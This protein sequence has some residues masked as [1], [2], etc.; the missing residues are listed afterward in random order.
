[1]RVSSEVFDKMKIEKIFP[2]AKENWNTLYVQFA[3]V[4]SVQTFYKNSRYLQSNQRLIPYI[5]KELYP[6]FKEL[7]SIAY[8]LR[9][10]DMKYKTKVDIGASGLMLYKRK[11]TC[12]S[13]TAVLTSLPTS[14]SSKPTDPV[15]LN[16][17]PQ[18][19]FYSSSS[20]NLEKNP[21]SSS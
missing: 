11:P 4:S 18:S 8:N 12:G 3:S 19:A 13:W 15:H 6:R 10:S 9:H 5:P 14:S 1:M 21:Q 7:Q 16:L 17:R 20:N 2:P